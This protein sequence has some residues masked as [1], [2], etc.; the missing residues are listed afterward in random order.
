[1]DKIC[2][3]CKIRKYYT[4]F[5]KSKSRKD[6][7]RA[8]C[9]QC[10]K[11][12]YIRTIDKVIERT[13]QYRKLN[14]PKIDEYV[15][16]YNKLNALKIRERTKEYKLLNALSIRESNK[17]YRKLNALKI[18]ESNKQYR[19]DNADRIREVKKQHHLDNSEHY[20]Q[21]RIDNADKIKENMKQYYLENADKLKENYKKYY[22]LN[23][24]T[25]KERLKKNNQTEHGKLVNKVRN[26]KRKALLKA[27]TPI[28]KHHTPADIILK[29]KL[30]K[31]KC[32]YCEKS[33]KNGYQID[34]FI[35][36]IKNGSNEA[37][38]IQLLCKE[39]NGSGG[40]GS[41]LPHE[42]AHQHGMLF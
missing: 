27:N 37:W 39:C 10:G 41:K 20:K 40:K 1:M 19:L 24:T 31:G 35:P 34:H 3:T 18:K 13:K 32:V 25:I 16:K 12:Y 29:L 28:G 36:A 6:G 11:E 23:A 42:F 7:Y 26:H 2:C 33:L 22:K 8:E 5:Y 21:Y 30:Q 14:K 4:E 38:N 9:K 15:K 17:Q